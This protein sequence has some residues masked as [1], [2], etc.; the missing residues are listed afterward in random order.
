MDT[1]LVLVVL[2]YLLV[3]LIIY[4]NRQKFEIHANII[5]LYR[6]KVGIRAMD[7]VVEKVPF[8]VK[9]FGYIG[10]IFGFVGMGYISYVMVQGAYLLLTGALVDPVVSPV[11]PGVRIPGSP[12]FVPF[13]Y[14]IISIF[15]VAAIH[16]FSHGIVARVHK[17]EV[18]N[19][20][21]VFFGPI[22]GA[23][24]EPDEKE[25]A[26]VS[27]LKRLSVFSAGP[28]SNIVTG[29]L[30]LLCMVFVLAP[31]LESVVKSDGIMFE[32]VTALLPADVAGF[33]DGDV[34]RFVD[35]IK[36]ENTLN[37][38][39]VMRQYDVGD[40]AIFSDGESSHEVEFIANPSNDSLPFMGVT[41]AG[42]YVLKDDVKARY[43]S[44][45]LG[46]FYVLDLFKWI[47]ILSLGIGLANLL[48]L[49]PVDGGRMVHATLGKFFKEKKAIKV[50][51]F[52]SWLFVFLL[53]FNLFYPYVKHLF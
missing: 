3:I 47:F 25:L 34:I 21:V 53:L 41:I 48:P 38:T 29:I 16:E 24:V 30:V 39:S 43:G 23:F 9:W 28:F 19:T 52:V 49:G 44:F 7:K 8:L 2:F 13:W 40:K 14:G 17:I 1:N 33:T 32:S 31:A 37:F 5:A 26:K 50:W 10:I 36:I 42:N 12:L 22:I 20:G 11:I 6:T 15:I 51:S 45:P 35:D 27:V 18:K 46:L 4:Y